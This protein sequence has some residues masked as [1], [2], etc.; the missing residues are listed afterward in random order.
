MLEDFLWVEKY[1]PRKLEDLVLPKETEES[2]KKYLESGEIPN[3][4]FVGPPGSGKTTL[5]RVILDLI[6]QTPDDFIVLNGSDTRGIA[7]VRDV[8]VGFLS[9]PVI[10]S[11]HKQKCV[12][13]DEFDGFTNDAFKSLR[14]TIEKY[15]KTGRFLC[16]A[17]YV[18]KIP[19]PILSR[20]QVYTFDRI[21]T[22]F[23]RDYCKRILESENVK[24]DPN[25]IE[26]LVANLY[27]DIR[28]MVQ[29][30]QQFSIDG[31]LKHLTADKIQGIEKK[32]VALICE[33]I[34]SAQQGK[35]S[36][37]DKTLS[38]L[39]NELTDYNVNY[40]QLYH[41]LFESKIPVWS[42][43]II[44]KYANDHMHCLSPKMHF[45]ALVFEVIKRAFES[46]NSLRR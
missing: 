11:R 27:P 12:F 19:D 38:F 6:Y 18:F 22:S 17:N 29:V 15:S 32:I 14:H 26:L 24:Y 37:V 45:M 46:K 10:D 23:A 16:T 28:K 39:V 36:I 43:V 1:R 8:V 42:K 20:F 33:S 41:D 40:A 4:L 44:N 25:D 7:T 5:A 35:R 3:L 34:I 31:E 30:L 9:T 13:I 2:I 21:P